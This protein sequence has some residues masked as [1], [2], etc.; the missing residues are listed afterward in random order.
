ML[1][2]WKQKDPPML[3]VQPIFIQELKHISF[4]VANLLPNSGLI[5]ATAD[6]IIALS[7]SPFF[8]QENTP[9]P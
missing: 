4:V 9:I 3:H 1:A 2:V 7:S 8:A 6:M 5:Q